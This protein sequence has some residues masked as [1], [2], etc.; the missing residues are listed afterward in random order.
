MSSIL[1]IIH[2]L[3]NRLSNG[4]VV[5]VEKNSK[6]FLSFLNNVFNIFIKR[7][8]KLKVC[9]IVLLQHIKYFSPAFSI[10]AV[11]L[12]YF[13]SIKQVNCFLEK[14]CQA[15]FLQDIPSVYKLN[16]F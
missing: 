10:L 12:G 9:F 8:Y 3:S 4:I 6:V 16:L 2:V 14:C 13:S 11:Q 1:S 5:K 7:I 15:F